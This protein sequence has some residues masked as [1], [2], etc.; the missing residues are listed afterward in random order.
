MFDLDYALPIIDRQQ[1]ATSYRNI[2]I[3]LKHSLSYEPLVTLQSVGVAYQCYYART[4]GKNWPFYVAIEGSLSVAWVRQ[5]IAE[6]LANVNQA[7][8]PFNVELLVLDAYRPI[9]CQ[10]NLWTF[11]L[12]QAKQTMPDVSYERQHAYALRNVTDPSHFS[13]SDSTSWPVH[14]TG[15]A[16]DVILRK[17]DSNALLDM[18][19]QFSEIIDVSLSHYFECQLADDKISPADVRLQ[20]RRL[21]HWAM[22][23]E[24]FYND[25]SLFW[26]FDWGNQAYIKIIQLFSKEAPKVA[27]YGYIEPPV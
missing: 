18:G 6:K 15:S 22:A 12:N 9:S 1:Y 4:D 7:L 13:P 24:G 10:Q 26:H 14:T 21:L 23:Q 27:W 8:L 19:S 25:P 11:F 20:N 2:P 3:D 17:T 5:S 16:V